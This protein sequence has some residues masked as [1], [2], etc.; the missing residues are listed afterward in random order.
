MSETLAVGVRSIDA[1]TLV[2]RGQRLAIF[3]GSGVGKSTLLAM[4]A[5]GTDA[6]VT[7]LALVGER[8]REVREFLEEEL[9]P[10][11]RAR[12]V[13]I[14]STSDQ[15]PLARLRAGL[16]AARVAEHF[17][18]QGREALLLFDSLTRFAMAQRE[19]GLAAGEPA[20]ARGYT[21]SVFAALDR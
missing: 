11:A 14:V 13:V 7:V 19:V 1:L 20:T 16:V 5:R 12:A 10:E 8:G 4:T 3:G 21:P 6:D 18:D 2:A 15:P 9:S 17:A